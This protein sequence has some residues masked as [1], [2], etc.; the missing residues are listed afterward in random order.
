MTYEDIKNILFIILFWVEKEDINII[1]KE[2]NIMKKI[3]LNN[4]LNN[5][6]KRI[7][8][9]KNFIN[10]IVEKKTLVE[11]NNFFYDNIKCFSL[12]YCYNNFFEEK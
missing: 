5:G 8:S 12:Y 3:N 11:M 1:C 9:I 4:I 2:N 10:E 7:E 6:K